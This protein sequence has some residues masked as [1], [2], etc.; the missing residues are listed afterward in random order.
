M[1]QLTD[2][3][4][5]NLRQREMKLR[6]QRRQL[7]SMD[8]QTALDAILDAPSPATL[9]QSF[10]DQDLYYLMHHVGPRDFVP[11]LALARS[12]QWEHILDVETWADDRM[13]LAVTAKTF[14]LLFQADPERFLRWIIKEKPDYFEFFLSKNMTIVI[15]E[16]DDPPPSDFDDYITLDDKFYFRF[17]EPKKR[18][19]ARTGS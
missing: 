18:F 7:L 14:D 10:P 12:D 15:R 19:A 1:N 5:A 6:E 3:K 8:G 2:R 9:V 11:V 17:P 4:L 16:H 13:D